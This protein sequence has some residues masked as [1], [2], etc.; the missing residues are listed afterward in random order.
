VALLAACLES[1]LHDRG[2]F[3]RLALASACGVLVMGATP[4]G[5]ALFPDVLLSP[6]RSDFR[7]ITEW[8]PAGRE[9]WTFG[10]FALVAPLG[11][12][13]LRSWSTLNGRER[14]L[15]YVAGAI[16]PLAF[17]SSRIVAIFTL[18][19]APLLSGL[20]LRLR[21]ARALFRSS[22]PR[23]RPYTWAPATALAVA[24]TAVT[25]VWYARLPFL[26]W[27][28]ISR[29]AVDAIR[30]CGCPM[31]NH[32]DNGGPLI[33]FVPE[34]PVFIDGRQHPYPASFVVEHFDVED[35]GN[36]APLFARYGFRCAVLP[37]Y[38]KVGQAL[39]RDGWHVTYKDG[40]WVVAVRP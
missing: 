25:L 2:R 29:R 14:L 15:A 13:T 38:S 9:L 5:F 1:L 20:V 31:Y 22:P 34:Q 28:P 11:V 30:A 10:L 27:D 12:L 23:P 16:L 40:A 3:P 36:Y 26:G 8:Q 37:P 7:Y 32:Y 17:M 6:T 33:W 4:L 24:A 19:A 18:A 39:T 21:G 35:S